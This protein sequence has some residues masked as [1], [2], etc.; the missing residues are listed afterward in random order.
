M[1]FLIFYFFI[2]PS[3]VRGGQRKILNL[4]YQRKRRKKKS[5][6]TLD[7]STAVEIICQISKVINSS[8]SFPN[9]THTNLPLW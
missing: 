9:G 2:L 4:C 8:S 1:K 5:Q 6:E 3:A 7:F